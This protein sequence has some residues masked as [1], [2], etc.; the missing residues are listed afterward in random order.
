MRARPFEWSDE[1]AVVALWQA[2]GLVV[3]WNDPRRDIRLKMA[4]QPDLFFVGERDG[5]ILATVM[6]GYEGHR[7]WVNYLAVRP[8]RRGEGLGAQMMQAAEQALRALGC[9]KLNLQVRRSNAE[10][11]AFYEGLGF[12]DD[13][14]IGLGKWLTDPS[15]D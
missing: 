6:A 1:D 5:E 8:D 11:L 4:F 15:E 2:C 9:V 10:V 12:E 7:G 14:V 3:P 13:D